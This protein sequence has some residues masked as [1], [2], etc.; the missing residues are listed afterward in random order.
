MKNETRL[1]IQVLIY[2]IKQYTVYF[3][4]YTVYTRNKSYLQL[5]RVVKCP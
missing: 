1:K 3:T 2:N 4:V 5:I